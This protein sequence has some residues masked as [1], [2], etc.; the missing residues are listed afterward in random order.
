MKSWGR[1]S[2][3][4]GWHVASVSRSQFLWIQGFVTQLTI[5]YIK[6]SGQGLGEGNKLREWHGAPPTI[7][8]PHPLPTPFAR[9]WSYPEFGLLRL[10]VSLS[11]PSHLYR[12]LTSSPWDWTNN[13][14]ITEFRNS[15]VANGADGDS[16]MSSSSD[17]THHRLA[18]FNP[19]NARRL[20]NFFA[21]RA[22]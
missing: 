10:R 21:N 19:H 8:N 2:F 13:H 3:Q 1:R 11:S 6:G 20:S 15:L 9:T 16:V 18:D 4:K 17:L 12:S 5:L 7:P 22:F 14:V